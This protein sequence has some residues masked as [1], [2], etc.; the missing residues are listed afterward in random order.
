[1][2]IQAEQRERVATE[3]AAQ[4]SAIQRELLKSIDAAQSTVSNQRSK[5][6]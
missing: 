2:L 4:A 6:A 1:M 5:A 3:A